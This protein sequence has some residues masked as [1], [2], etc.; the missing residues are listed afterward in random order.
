MGSQQLLQQLI[1]PNTKQP[2][3][4]LQIKYIS[5]HLKN[6]FD[7]KGFEHCWF[8]GFVCVVGFLLRLVLGFFLVCCGVFVRLFV[9]QLVSDCFLKVCFHGIFQKGYQETMERVRSSPNCRKQ[10]TLPAAINQICYC[11]APS[12]D[13]SL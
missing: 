3:V 11:A 5:V 7:F 6:V 13:G 4:S 10:Q 8:L 2:A 1:T 12:S 9:F